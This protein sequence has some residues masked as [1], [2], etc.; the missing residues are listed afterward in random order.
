MSRL[1][2]FSRHTAWLIYCRPARGFRFRPTCVF[3][4]SRPSRFAGS[5][6]HPNFP[7]LP[8]QEEGN[9]PQCQD[10]PGQDGRHQLAA[11]PGV[12]VGIRHA[13][14]RVRLHCDDCA[15]VRPRPGGRGRPSCI[16]R[17]DDG[18]CLQMLQRVHRTG[19]NICS[20]SSSSSVVVI[21]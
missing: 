2:F 3:P 16:A 15:G 18:A 21:M 8:A 13:G 9:S 17:T 4:A 14:Q 5:S 10:G 7:S 12:A 11:R 6:F 19:T 1:E 20:S